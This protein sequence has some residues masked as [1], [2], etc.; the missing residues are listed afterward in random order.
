MTTGGTGYT[1]A[2][3]VAFSGGGFSTAATALAELGRDTRNITLPY[4]GFPG[5]GL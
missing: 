2:P 5:A 1:S 4:G 3:T